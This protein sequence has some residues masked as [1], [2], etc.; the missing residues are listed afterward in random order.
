MYKRQQTIPFAFDRLFHKCCRAT[1]IVGST[2]DP[3]LATTQEALDLIAS[4]QADAKTMLTHQMPFEE[5][6]D[7]YQ[8]HAE[9]LDR[10]VKI[11]IE[12]PGNHE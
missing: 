8:M 7:A 9:R 1:T 5:V 3:K 12:M 4:G 10:A 6:L 2:D 11:I